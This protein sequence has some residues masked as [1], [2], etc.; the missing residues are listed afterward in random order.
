MMIVDLDGCISADE[1]RWLQVDH[2]VIDPDQRYHI[3]HMQAVDDLPANLHELTHERRVIMTARPLRYRQLTQAWL[4]RHEIQFE[5]LLM[6]NNLDHRSSVQIKEE[7]LTQW[8]PHYGIY[9]DEIALAIDDQK[10]IV[11]MYQHHGVQAKL[12]RIGN[13]ARGSAHLSATQ[14]VIRK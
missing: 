6:R 7:M 1:W 10:E 11:Q 13:Y 4:R 8:L 9:K 5:L 12:I 14:Q 2:S 3:Y